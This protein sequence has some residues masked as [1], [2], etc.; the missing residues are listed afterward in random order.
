MISVKLIF[1]VILEQNDL[2][3]HD[4]NVTDENIE[5][6][7]FE[8]K[9]LNDYLNWSKKELIALNEDELYKC[10]DYFDLTDDF[11]NSLD[12]AINE[13]NVLI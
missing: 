8:E 2:D 11:L 1:V 5:S 3:N 4:I 9:V 7:A 12:V 6:K 10:S 13:V